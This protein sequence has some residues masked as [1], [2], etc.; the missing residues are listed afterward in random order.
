MKSPRKNWQLNC[1]Y[2]HASLNV[3]SIYYFIPRHSDT[4]TNRRKHRNV[5]HDT[6]CSLKT[7][8]MRLCILFVP[9][10]N[11]WTCFLSASPARMTLKQ[12][13]DPETHS[14]PPA[15]HCTSYASSISWTVSVTIW[16][17]PTRDGTGPWI[18]VIATQSKW[19]ITSKLLFKSM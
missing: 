13:H 9:L 4:Q 19:I 2:S 7:S 16:R 8:T 11:I 17:S 1:G 18:S 10:M 12:G 14:H 15:Q 5:K 6:Q 3:F